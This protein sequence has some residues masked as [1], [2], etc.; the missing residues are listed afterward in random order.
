MLRRS[1]LVLIALTGCVDP[2][3][4]DD[5]LD[6]GCTGKCDGAAPA[7]LRDH[8]LGNLLAQMDSGEV[9][10]G[11]QRFNVTGVEA[12]GTQWLATA[13]ALE[14]SDAK[15][16]TGAHPVVFGFDAWDLAIKPATWTPTPAVHAAA[17]KSVYA[18]G[19]VVTMD[20]HMR[21]CGADSFG[22]AGN[23]HCLCRLA[24]DD[25]YAR[26]WLLDGNYAKV[27][28]ALVAHGLDRIP[29]VFRPL[30]EH[31]GS[32]FW[33]G[34]NY[35]SCSGAVTGEA[36]Y[37]RVY[38]TIVTYLREER[39]LDNLLIAYSPDR[40]GGAGDVA[41]GDAQAYLRGYPG[42]AYVDI[43]GI[44]L[45]YQQA[46]SF[47]P[48]TQ[49]FRAYLATIER[50]ARE[51]GKATAL[52]EVGNTQLAA[53]QT[54]GD[55]RWFT[56]HLLP[57]LRDA[58]LAYAMTWENRTG[59]PSG[60]WIPYGSH[61]GVADFRAFAADATTLFLDEVPALYEKPAKF[62]ICASC[63]ADPD[64]DRW[65]WE[66]STSCRVASWCLAR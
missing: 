43:L 42:D 21:G 56:Q 24:N 33:W 16:L 41:T 5:E 1:L 45:Y 3:A 20:W 48:Q 66:H 25:A 54:S 39:G 50:L 27:A 35:W 63:T 59:T 47:A 44:D 28:D 51:R 19:G 32:W 49:A 22:A 13:S 15:T 60:F 2:G 12:N 52:T 62:P 64:G 57:L 10:F 8:L 11:Q 23:E 34:Q 53:E 65:G 36:A 37:Q 29:I 58:N 9:L 30:H 18:H 38:R 7:A 40:F 6:P 4:P 55:S 31:N 14:R 26:A 17:A 61:P 46:T